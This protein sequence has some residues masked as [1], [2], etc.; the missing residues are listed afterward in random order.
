MA[1]TWN[2]TRGDDQRLKSCDDIRI[3]SIADYETG[4][5]MLIEDLYFT[6][7][8]VLRCYRG[9]FKFTIDGTG[10]VVLMQE[11]LLV[12]H[13][14]HRVT[15]EALDTVNRLVYVIVDGASSG[16]FLNSLGYFDGFRSQT[17]ANYGN[18]G[19]L[20]RQLGQPAGEGLDRQRKCLS[21][22]ADILTSIMHGIKSRNDPLVVK[23][24]AVIRRNL[25]ARIVRIEPVCDELGICRSH[26]HRLFKKAGLPTPGDFIKS[27]QE[28]LAVELLKHTDFTVDEIARRVGFLQ[29]THFSTFMRKRTGKSPTETR[30]EQ[31]PPFADGARQSTFTNI[32]NNYG[33]ASQQI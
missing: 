25:G 15:I 18:I 8:N 12:I 24:M 9:R 2:E 13:P 4:P 30:R 14:G 3:R 28:R 6:G 21:F 17:A 16:R 23:A 19:E 33:A 5:K 11:E 29:A 22:L 10:P 27:E 1:S 31:A 32:V 7:A 26:L 20:R